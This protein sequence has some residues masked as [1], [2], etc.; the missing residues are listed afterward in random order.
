MKVGMN[1]L[2]ASMLEIRCKRPSELRVPLAGSRRRLVDPEHARFVAVE[3]Q[4]LSIV[5]EILMCRFKISKRRLGA[6]EQHDHQSARGVVNV[7]QRRARRRS[8]LKP[9]MIAAVDL[10]EFA[11][12]SSATPWLLDLRRP[13]S[14][15]HP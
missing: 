13:K 15:R 4:R 2:A 11:K 10:D 14:P 8:V 1:A 3:R 6:D 9:T 5:L 7:D 12:A